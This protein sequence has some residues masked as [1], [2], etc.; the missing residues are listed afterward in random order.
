M[1]LP[2][3]LH[4]TEVT[5]VIGAAVETACQTAA[6]PVFPYHDRY[7]SHSEPGAD[8]LHGYWEILSRQAGGPASSLHLFGYRPGRGVPRPQMRQRH[9]SSGRRACVSAVGAENCGG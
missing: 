9:F 1:K 5:E 3:S 6:N 7:A 4:T 8:R 2:M